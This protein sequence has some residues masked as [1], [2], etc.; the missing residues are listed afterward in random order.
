LSELDLT[1][2][3]FDFA[4]LTNTYL[5]HSSLTN[6]NLVGANL[7]NA[8]LEYSTLTN[9]NLVGANLTNA[10][11]GS[12]R[13]INANLTGAGVT[14]A[15]FIDTTR[16]GFTHAQLASTSSYQTK[17]L[18]GIDLSSNNLTGWDFT[19]QNLTGAHLDESTLPIR[20]WRGRW[21]TGATLGARGFTQAQL[22]STA[23]YQTKNLH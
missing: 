23:S 12:S 6:A 19:G 18:Q 3:R 17:N 16:R 10:Y 1:G 2:A 22:V 15:K 9:A 20:T 11:L 8:I 21:V 5:Q 14:G 13:L 7:T 4:N